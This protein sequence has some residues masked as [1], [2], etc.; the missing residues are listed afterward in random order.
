MK[1]PH[2]MSALT[3]SVI[4]VASNS[5]VAAS[6]YTQ[7][8]GSAIELSG[9]VTKAAA[10][11]FN[12]DY[13]PGTIKVELDDYD[14]YKEGN[15][16]V[17]GDRV[18]VNG[19]VDADPGKTRSI[20][21]SKVYIPAIDLEVRASSVDEE[22]TNTKLFTETLEDG[23]EVNLNG[24]ITGIDKKIVTIQ[25]SKGRVD[26]HFG[27]LFKQKKTTLK[28]G[29]AVKVTG[30]FQNRVFLKD[31]IFAEKVEKLRPPTSEIQPR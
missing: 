3:F 7:S 4:L 1:I 11:Y 27:K 17:V 21:A 14:S 15:N 12:L 19:R 26:I 30:I 28:V 31:M 20:E 8:N 24:I 29:Q 2:L 9:L 6:P 25:S 16:I 18:V 10:S 22:D 5:L 13:G 23:I